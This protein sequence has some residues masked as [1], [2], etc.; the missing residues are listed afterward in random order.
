MPTARDTVKEP[1]FF[2][3]IAL[4]LGFFPLAWGLFIISKDL[5]GPEGA[6]IGTTVGAAGTMAGIGTRYWF[7]SSN[8][9]S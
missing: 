8:D 7:D 5:T 1:R 6:L 9:K 4:Y 3:T 2:L